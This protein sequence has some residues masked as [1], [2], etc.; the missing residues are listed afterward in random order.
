MKTKLTPAQLKVYTRLQNGE[1]VE[2]G[3]GTQLR[4][5]Q[6]LEE[7]G[8][9][10]LETWSTYGN[11][12]GDN[13]LAWTVNLVAVSA[14]RVGNYTIALFTNPRSVFHPFSVEVTRPATDNDVLDLGYEIGAPYLLVSVGSFDLLGAQTD[15]ED[16]AM[17][18]EKITGCS[19]E[20]E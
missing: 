5:V 7:A 6:A 15:Y 17:E 9:V 11:I 19:A 20:V 3:D 18:Y 10:R 2:Q 4:T 1:T 16:L 13:G 14:T 12:F 8:L